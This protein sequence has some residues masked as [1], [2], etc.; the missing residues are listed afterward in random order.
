MAIENRRECADCGLIQRLP[1]IPDGEA[2]AC[3]RCA[4][5]LR[6]ADVD[7]VGFA[8]VA[9]VLAT[10]LFALALSTPA[11]ELRLMGRSTTSTLFTG[12]AAL[13]GAQLPGL[14]VVVLFALAIMPAVKL[15]L[16]LLVLFGARSGRRPPWLRWGFAWLDRIAPWSMVEVFLLGSFVAYSRLRALAHVE[17]GPGLWALGGAMVCMVATDTLDREALWEELEPNGIRTLHAP[18]AA[19]GAAPIGCDACGWVET[20]I[21]G[22]R[23]ARCN[24]VVSVRKANSLARTWAFLVAA[25]LLYLP[26]NMLPV[27]TVKQLGRGGPT[28][29][30]H[31]VVELA[32]QR[33][34]PLAALV[35]LASIVVPMIKLASL[36]ALLIM[37]HLGSAAWLPGRTRLFRFLR[38]IGRWSM[39]DVFMLSILVGAVRLG[40]IATVAPGTGAAAFCA[41]VIATMV[42]TEVFDP[43]LMW[44]AAQ[45][46]T[47]KADAP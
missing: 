39:I 27:M 15:T 2:A 44:D 24:H 34:W 41:V 22:D 23:C 42:A 11:L 43:R 6:R 47:R 1:P 35:L 46:G 25:V 36:A 20:A 7:S 18:S 10:L 30:L 31:G 12:P 5:L 40:A 37:T 26:A 45:T 19:A 9:A 33:L 32:R 17:V 8:R 3:A 29:I 13:R 4:R 38:A 14:A 28:T 21:E 16:E